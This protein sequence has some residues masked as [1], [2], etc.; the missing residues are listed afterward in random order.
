VKRLNRW[1]I[2]GVN[3]TGKQIKL[4]KKILASEIQHLPWLLNEDPVL[5]CVIER[6]LNEQKG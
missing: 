4:L 5:N 1:W 3:L 2:N 6:R